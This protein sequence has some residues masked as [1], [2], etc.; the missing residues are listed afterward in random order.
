MYRKKTEEIYSNDIG[1]GLEVMGLIF[2]NHPVVMDD[3]SLKWIETYLKKP[4]N[5]YSRS[6]QSPPSWHSF[7]YL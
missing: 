6:H 1:G 3:H 2:S 7:I 4:T 5:G